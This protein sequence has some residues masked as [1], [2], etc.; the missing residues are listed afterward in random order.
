[1]FAETNPLTVKTAFA[2]LGL[3]PAEMVGSADCESE[4]AFPFNL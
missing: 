2:H 3:C 4:A 1:M